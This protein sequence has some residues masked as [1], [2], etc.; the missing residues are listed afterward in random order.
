ML[1]DKREGIKITEDINSLLIL[2]AEEENHQRVATVS[3]D[4]S[5]WL[6]KLLTPVFVIIQLQIKSGITEAVAKY[7]F[8]TLLCY[9]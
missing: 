7:E 5:Q 4:D 9:A 1:S 6:S 8:C 3:P 2:F